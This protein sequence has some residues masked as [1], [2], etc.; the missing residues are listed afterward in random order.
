MNRGLVKIILGAAMVVFGVVIL[1]MYS[2]FSLFM[3]LD[4]NTDIQFLVP[5]ELRTGIGKAGQY[6]LVFE[7]NTVLDGKTYRSAPQLPDGW[8]IQVTAPNGKPMDFVGDVERV[9]EGDYSKTTTSIKLGSVE[10]V[11]PGDY[12]VSVTGEGEE[13]VFSFGRSTMV[14][15][16][17]FGKK[18]MMIFVPMVLVGMAMAAWG[19]L[20]TLSDNRKSGEGHTI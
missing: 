2:M 19:L 18:Q 16:L 7:C 12:T 9:R 10:I 13:L 6:E 5:G 8:E 11:S 15:F 14:D 17:D 1:P 3:S 20:Q 4:E